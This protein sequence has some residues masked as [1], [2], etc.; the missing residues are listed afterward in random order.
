MFDLGTIWLKIYYYFISHKY[1][2]R[3]WWVIVLIAADAF[4]VVFVFTNFALYL[5]GIPRQNNIM[6]AMAANQVDY[7]AIR[8]LSNPIE[9]G[10]G[11]SMALMSSNNKFNLV[12]IVKNSNRNWVVEKIEYKYLFQNQETEVMTDS[13]MPDSDKYLIVQGVE[14]AGAARPGAE[15]E[16]EI[17]L[18]IISVSWKRVIDLDELAKVNFSIDDINYSKSSAPG[19]LSIHS[20]TANITNNY[21]QGFWDSRFIILLLAGQEI[22][23]VDYVYF[24][25]FDSKETL[26]IFSQ[27]DFIPVEVSKVLIL[28]DFNFIDED[29][30]YIRN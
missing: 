19:G 28:P 22:A 7:Q 12:S 1:D 26:K 17:S 14:W 24:D 2:L 15:T 11:S 5:I 20:I 9:L 21:Y 25:E 8:E 10:V 4:I 23:A 18:E 27:V 29:N 6:V 16:F 30:L 3:K 13:I